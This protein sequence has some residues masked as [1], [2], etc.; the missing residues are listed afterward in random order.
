MEKAGCRHGEMECSDIHERSV[1]AI[2]DLRLTCATLIKGEHFERYSGRVKR[3]ASIIK[4][5]IQLLL[6]EWM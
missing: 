3:W 2:S 6:E 5:S 1:Q 4:C